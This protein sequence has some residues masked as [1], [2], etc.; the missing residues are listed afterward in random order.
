M[1][2]KWLVIGGRREAESRDFLERE[3]VQLII[4]NYVC[5]VPS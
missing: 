3:N 2:D 4:F 1:F 5:E